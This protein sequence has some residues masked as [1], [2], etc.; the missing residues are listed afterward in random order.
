[1]SAEDQKAKPNKRDVLSTHTEQE[2]NGF[3]ELAQRF[4]EGR[5]ADAILNKFKGEGIPIPLWLSLDLA[6]AP[7]VE[8]EDIETASILFKVKRHTSYLNSDG[9]QEHFT[10]HRRK[11]NEI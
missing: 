1:M 8:E 11:W 4:G 10:N 2:I 6:D 5:L 9:K 7:I 3:K